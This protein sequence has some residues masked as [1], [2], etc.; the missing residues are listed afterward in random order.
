MSRYPPPPPTDADNWKETGTTR[1]GLGSLTP[2]CETMGK[3][4]NCP[5][6]ADGRDDNISKTVAAWHLML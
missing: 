5:T 6:P 4:R 3:A 1:G 2:T